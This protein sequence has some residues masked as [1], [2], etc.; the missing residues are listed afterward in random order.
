MMIPFAIIKEKEKEKEEDDE[1]KKSRSKEVVRRRDDED[2]SLPCLS[3]AEF[4][5][6]FLVF[7]TTSQFARTHH[8]SS[9]SSLSSCFYF[10]FH[11][12][13]REG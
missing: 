7:Y 8:Q 4:D 1:E 9:S 2:K 6:L 3:F 12:E 10:L 5:R 11:S 13:A